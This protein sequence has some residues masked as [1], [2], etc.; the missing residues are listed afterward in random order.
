[1]K[2]IARLNSKC[3][4]LGLQCKDYLVEVY[5]N[6]LIIY[7]TAPMMAAEV[8]RR[9]EVEKWEK[10]AYRKMNLLPRDING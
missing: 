4:Q 10:M 5:A 6:S 1:M 3:R 2:H 7:A 9:K 8:I